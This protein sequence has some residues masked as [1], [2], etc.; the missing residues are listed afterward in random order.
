M[1]RKALSAT[2]FDISTRFCGRK[3]VR[4]GEREKQDHREQRDEGAQPHQVERERAEPRLA[5]RGSAAA[6]MEALPFAVPTHARAMPDGRCGDNLGLRRLARDRGARSGARW[7]ITAMRSESASTSSRSE[8]T[9]T[10]PIPCAARLRMMRKTSAFAPMSMPRLGSSIKRTF[11][12]VSSALPITTFCWLPPE[13]DETG[14][15]GSATLIDRSLIS[16]ARPPRPR[17]AP[18][19]ENPASACAGSPSS[20]SRR[21]KGWTRV[22][23]AG[24]P[25]G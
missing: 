22:R 8:V 19:C 6:L 15:A 20:D 12:E 7:L 2:C 5:F 18:E 23:R 4:R 10:I 16:R 25:R 24:D 14:S 1:A 9:K 11:G 21:P 3:K 17:R 13:S